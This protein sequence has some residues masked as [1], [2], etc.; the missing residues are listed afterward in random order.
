MN[1]SNTKVTGPYSQQLSPTQRAS[2][3]TSKATSPQ[4]LNFHEPATADYM[5][6]DMN[7]LNQHYVDLDTDTDD[8]YNASR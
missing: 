6:Q 2:K 8:Q 5:N 4:R 3:L 7:M 1:V